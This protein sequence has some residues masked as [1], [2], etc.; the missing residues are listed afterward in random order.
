M[1][2]RIIRDNTML[3]E[4]SL[5]YYASL[6]WEGGSSGGESF[7]FFRY[8]NALSV[9]PVTADLP[10]EGGWRLRGTPCGTTLVIE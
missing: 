6:Q 1:Q 10:Q 8:L 5:P 3:A 2:W 7:D 9:Q 4:S